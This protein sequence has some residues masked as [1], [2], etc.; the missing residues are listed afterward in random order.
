MGW[1]IMVVILK[2]LLEALGSS[3]HLCIVCITI[4]WDT[5][6]GIGI[7]WDFGRTVGWMRNLLRIGFLHY[8]KFHLYVINRFQDSFQ[9]KLKFFW[10]SL[11]LESISRFFSTDRATEYFDISMAEG[12]CGR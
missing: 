1:R 9:E 6:Q 10:V 12:N 5:K 8:L 7:K 2:K 11:S 4:L 3:S